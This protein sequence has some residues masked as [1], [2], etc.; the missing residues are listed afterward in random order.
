MNKWLIESH[1]CCRGYDKTWFV[2][3]VAVHAIELCLCVTS[4]TGFTLCVSYVATGVSLVTRLVKLDILIFERRH[5]LSL[6]GFFSFPS[7]PGFCGY[8]GDWC[9]TLVT[10]RVS[11]VTT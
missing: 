8:D 9:V 5:N 7:S 4:R 6:N 10:A 3:T 11:W 2:Y 1:P